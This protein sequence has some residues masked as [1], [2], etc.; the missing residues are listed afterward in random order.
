MVGR[1]YGWQAL[2]L[3]RSNAVRNSTVTTI[4]EQAG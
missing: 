4:V 2:A 1:R 3:R